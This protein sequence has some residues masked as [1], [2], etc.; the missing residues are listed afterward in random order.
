[1]ISGPKLAFI[2]AV[3]QNGVIG[4]QGKLPWHISSDLKFFKQ[5]TLGKPVL[6][7]RTTWEGLPF[8]LP[9]RPNLVLT[10]NRD[11]V[12]PPAEIYHDLKSFVG[13]GFELAGELGQDE[14][15]VIG[16]AHIFTQLMPW[17]DRIYMTEVQAK[18]S[19]DVFFPPLDAS[20][21]DLS[22]QTEA[23]QGPKDDYEFIIKVYDR[24]TAKL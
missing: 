5:T 8:P 11:Y 4:N 7:G 6:M 16:G 2:V 19:G 20:M 3:A 14:V 18:V 21:W 1:M 24:K 12:S 10:H 9:G 22:S 17:A 23:R 13:R 15:M